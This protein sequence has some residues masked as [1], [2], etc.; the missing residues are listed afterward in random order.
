LERWIAAGG[1]RPQDGG[2]RVR[3]PRSKSG[4]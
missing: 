4:R 2:G 1:G 3:G